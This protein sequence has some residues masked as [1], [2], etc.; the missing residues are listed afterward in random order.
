M[1]D[2]GRSLRRLVM[3]AALIVVW[4]AGALTGCHA[5]DQVVGRYQDTADGGA[6]PRLQEGGRADGQATEADGDDGTTMPEGGLPDPITGRDDNQCGLDLETWRATT[7]C[8][9]P[10][11]WFRLGGER[12]N[13]PSEIVMI[14]INGTEPIMLAEGIAGDAGVSAEEICE[15]F[16]GEGWFFD[17]FF[18]PSTIFLCQK[19]CDRAV[20][21][22]D[23]YFSRNCGDA[24]IPPP[25]P[26]ALPDW[27]R[28]WPPGWPRPSWLDGGI[29]S[30]LDAGTPDP[31]DGSVGTV[32]EDETESPTEGAAPDP[33]SPRG[34][35]DDA[36]AGV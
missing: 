26:P 8:S 27:A 19:V 1:G 31:H 30:P 14:L 17:D 10:V 7:T 6:E 9:F 23:W 2:V 36:D 5:A 4:M 15:R 20:K 32:P 3:P 34:D 16:D 29:D 24:A 33:D 28:G 22:L 18:R 25:P 11:D 21:I 13:D 35:P 12:P